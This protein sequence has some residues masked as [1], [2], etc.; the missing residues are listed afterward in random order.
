MLAAR[1]SVRRQG[2]SEGESARIERL[3][4]AAGLP[5]TVTLNPAQRR[6]LFAAMLLDKKVSD[7][8]VKFVLAKRIGAVDFGCR[9]PLEVIEE[10]LTNRLGAETSNFKIQ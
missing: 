3:F 7:G 8:E 5:V 6:K 1:I 4:A 2:L 10:E 9:V